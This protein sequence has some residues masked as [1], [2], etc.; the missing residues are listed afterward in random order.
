MAACS[1]WVQLDR[2]CG[3]STAVAA[4][5]P[6]KKSLGDGGKDVSRREVRWSWEASKKSGD[7]RS[8]IY[9]GKF[10]GDWVEM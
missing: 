9:D 5:S 3:L 1:L 6:V 2:A 4:K 10:T 8:L 7:V